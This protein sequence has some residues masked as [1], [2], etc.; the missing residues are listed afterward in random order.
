MTRV[1]RTR[2]PSP[3][4]PVANPNSLDLRMAVAA[5]DS[6]PDRPQIFG[7]M[8]RGARTCAPYAALVSVHAN[9]LRGQRAVGDG[10]FDCD[11]IQG[12]RLPRGKVKSFEEVIT[13]QFPYVGQI[14]T[15]RSEERRV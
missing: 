6:A 9:G 14:V 10:R 15:G 5:L 11:I 7:L 4:G 1:L 12:I 3:R 2:A 13:T 8:L